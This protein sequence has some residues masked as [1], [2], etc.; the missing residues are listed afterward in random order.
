MLSVRLLVLD[1]HRPLTCSRP[2]RYDRDAS[3][4]H[5]GVYKRKRADLVG[6]LDS[7]LS[8]LFLGQLK[9]LHKACLVQFKTE[10]HEGMRGE[11]YNFAEIVAAARERCEAAF[12]AGAREA[13]PADGEEGAQWTYDDEFALLRE[14]MS[15]VADQCRRDET[16]KMVNVVEVSTCH[17]VSSFGDRN[18]VPLQRNFK[19]QISEPVELQLNQPTPDMWDKVLKV[20]RETLDKA[21]SAYLTK[22]Q[23]RLSCS[24]CEGYIAD[25]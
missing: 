25:S 18:H 3:R 5:Q 22:A 2:A 11:N 9:N 24:R 13:V 7:T 4:Y 17:I 12:D 14:E 1:K 20:F 6:V 23:S 10:M 15:S 16:K 8:P 19:K 21:E